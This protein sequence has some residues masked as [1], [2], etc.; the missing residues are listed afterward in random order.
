VRLK[1]RAVSVGGVSSLE[2]GFSLGAK[3]PFTDHV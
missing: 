3:F 1:P 2:L